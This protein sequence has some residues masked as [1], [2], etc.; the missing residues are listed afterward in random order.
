MKICLNA[1]NTNHIFNKKK[2]QTIYVSFPTLCPVA[3]STG[4]M[5]NKMSSINNSLNTCSLEV[6]KISRGQCIKLWIF[7]V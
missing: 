2:R 7:S 5:F 6:A 3:L 4:T 1:R